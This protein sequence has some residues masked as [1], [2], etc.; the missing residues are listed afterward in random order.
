M[1]LHVRDVRSGRPLVEWPGAIAVQWPGRSD[2]IMMTTGD[3]RG[4]PHKIWLLR[5]PERFAKRVEPP[6]VVLEEADDAQFMDVTLT[7]DEQLVLLHSHS[8]VASEVRF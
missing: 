8:K 3:V 7:K 2:C 4:R 5:M 6:R 1:T